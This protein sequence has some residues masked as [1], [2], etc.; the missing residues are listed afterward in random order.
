MSCDVTSPSSTFCPASGVA[1]VVTT[2]S[3]IVDYEVVLVERG[4][5]S[6]DEEQSSVEVDDETTRSVEEMMRLT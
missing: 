3:P 5:L 4:V 1:H 6:T 2:A